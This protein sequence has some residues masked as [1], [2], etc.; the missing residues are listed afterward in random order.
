MTMREMQVDG[1]LFEITMSQQHLDGAQ[2][3]SGF[4]QM[5]CKTMP[6][7]SHGR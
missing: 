4:E 5:R 2:V 6:P 7:I 1:G 3:G